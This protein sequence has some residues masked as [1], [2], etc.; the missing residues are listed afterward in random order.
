VKAAINGPTIKYTLG[1][2]DLTI[3]AM[4]AEMTPSIGLN[5]WAAFTGSMESAYIAGDVAM[6]D[7]EV[8]AVIKTLRAHNL[9]VVAVHNH[10]LGDKP[11]IIFLHYYGRGNAAALAH[12]FRAALDVLGKK[13]MGSMKM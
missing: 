6:L 9:E 7:H 2:K 11:H 4:G 12:G 5:T 13:P 1:R 10:M 3:L 8:N